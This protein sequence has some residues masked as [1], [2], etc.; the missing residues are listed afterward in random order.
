[1]DFQGKSVLVVGASSGMGRAI[2]LRFAQE[3][4]RVAV[5]ARRGERLLA[6]VEEIEA[7]GGV[8]LSL[9]A[10]GADEQGAAEVVSKVIT[11]WGGI[12]LVLLNAGGAPAL[13]MTAMTAAEV[14]SY[15]R[16]NYDT[17]VNYLFPVLDHMK[18]RNEGMVAHT[19]SLASFFGVPLAGPY[20]A[21]K[22][23]ARLLIDT[24][25]IEFEPFGIKFSTL[26]PGFI[27]TEAT[28][29]DGMPSPGEISEEEAVS[30]M[31]EAIRREDWDHMFPPEAAGEILQALELPKPVLNEILKEKILYGQGT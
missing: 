2:S 8:A 11:H 3:G 29:G 18:Q 21:A 13:R 25:R 23:A 9:P 5:T 31:I 7:A 14:K 28:K 30:Y 19:N 12:D 16:S 20:S 26:Y 6:L 17:V 24:C 22:A 10:D 4:A 15:M 27:A 1:M